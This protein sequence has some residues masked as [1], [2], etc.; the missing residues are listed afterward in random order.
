MMFR[1]KEKRSVPGLNTTSTADI[2]FMLLILF[3]V[4]SS[5]DLDRG[6]ARRL[7][8]IDRTK[9][10]PAAVDS[11]RVIRLVIDGGNRVTLDGKTVTMKE[12]RQR[13]VQ[14]VE[15]NGKGH[16]I[17]LQTDRL[18]CSARRSTSAAVNSRTRWPPKCPSVLRRYMLSAVWRR[19]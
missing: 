2:S 15:A 4:A 3:L 6:L 18:A 1:R 11:R 19:R 9:K 16:L 5:M 13:A 12:I 10:T 7:P 8:A 14:F 17:Q